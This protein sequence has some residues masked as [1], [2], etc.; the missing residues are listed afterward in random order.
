MQKYQIFQRDKSTKQGF[1]RSWMLKFFTGIT[2]NIFRKKI[3][4]H[5]DDYS[6]IY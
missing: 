4:L 5:S 3:F 1:K 6:R 2:Y